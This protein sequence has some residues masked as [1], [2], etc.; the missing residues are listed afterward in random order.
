MNT[1]NHQQFMSETSLSH[2]DS[3]GTPH[4]VNIRDKAVTAR[5]ARAEA[6][7]VFPPDVLAQLLENHWQSAKGGVLQTAVIAGTQA[8]K[9][10]S[11]LIPFC[12]PLPIDG[13]D[14]DMV[15]A[16]EGDRPAAA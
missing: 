9:K 15:E 10:T 5:S 13:C 7:V 6:K 4:M 16:E 1:P 2:I 3:S 11:D 12:H 8:V 14:S